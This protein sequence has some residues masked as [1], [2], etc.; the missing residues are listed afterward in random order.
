MNSSKEKNNFLKNVSW[1]FGGGTAS[2]V[3]AT[4]ETIFLARMLGVENFGLL[5]LVIAYVR[6]LNRFFDFRVWE[7]AVKYVGDF[8]ESG[9]KENARSMIKLSYLV[10]ISSGILAF[11]IAVLLAKLINTY[12]I[13]SEE[14]VVFIIIYSFSLLISTANSTSEAILRIYDKFKKIAFVNSFQ[15]FIRFLFVVISLFLGYGIKRCFT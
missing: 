9:Q 7:T 8:W 4:L 11:I 12:F 6:L 1:L 14:G 15:T 2:S 10:D 5:S 13:K 3:F